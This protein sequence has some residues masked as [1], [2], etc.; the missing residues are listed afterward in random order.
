MKYKDVEDF[1][2]NFLYKIETFRLNANPDTKIC[3][4]YTKE[5]PSNEDLSEYARILFPGYVGVWEQLK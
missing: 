5:R 2:T 3:K 1:W 4:L